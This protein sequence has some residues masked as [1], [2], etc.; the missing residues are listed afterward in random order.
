MGSKYSDCNSKLTIQPAYIEA[1]MTRKSTFPFI[2]TRQLIA[3]LFIG[4]PFYS[5]SITPVNL[6]YR[7]DS[8]PLEELLNPA[9]DGMRPR[10][11]NGELVRDED[12]TRHFEGE[13]V[14]GSTSAF[15]STTSTLENAVDIS[16][17]MAER[18]D[19][20]QLDPNAVLYIYAIRPSVDF[21]EIEGSFNAAIENAPPGSRRCDVL[22][23]LIRD[24]GNLDEWAAL[25]G[26]GADRIISV[27]E[28]TGA[29]LI[30]HEAAPGEMF[31]PEYWESRMMSN[32]IYST[33]SDNDTSNANPW[34]NVGESRGFTTEV[35]N[36]TA[37]DRVL[38]ADSCLG[39][40]P[41]TSSMLL[42]S[43]KTLDLACENRKKPLNMFRNFYYTPFAVALDLF[44]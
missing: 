22:R 6:V 24:Y 38:I 8:R 40:R 4:I 42:K 1:R 36:S 17:A 41:S 27:A 10:D 35:R 18:D 33:D 2:L 23:S 25:G 28:I 32:A 3:L 29:M 9:V 21:Y 7:I 31:S 20:G 12:L 11:N 34:H 39:V 16:Y 14:E 43:S 30:E 37:G 44:D 15:V 5:F 19:E 13:S 26:F